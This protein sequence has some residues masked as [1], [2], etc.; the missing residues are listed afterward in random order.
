LS[1][2]LI[3]DFSP[4]QIE[5]ISLSPNRR[6]AALVSFGPDQPGDQLWVFGLPGLP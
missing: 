1:L 3:R 2:T 5:Q 6:F 4:Q